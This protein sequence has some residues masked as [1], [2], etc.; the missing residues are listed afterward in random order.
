MRS[1]FSIP[2]K[3]ID[4]GYAALIVFVLSMGVHGLYNG[5]PRMLPLGLF[6]TLLVLPIWLLSRLRPDPEVKYFHDE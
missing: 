3:K 1:L 4:V 2:I 6:F 5:D